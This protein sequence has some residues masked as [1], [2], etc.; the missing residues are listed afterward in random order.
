MLGSTTRGA[1][2]TA[3]AAVAVPVLHA[4]D[5]ITAVL[6]DPSPR[7][8]GSSAS[9]RWCIAAVSHWYDPDRIGYLTTTL[10]AVRCQAA[11]VG[12]AVVT[13][14]PARLALALMV[15]LAGDDVDVRAVPLEA[16]G[17]FLLG[18]PDRIAVVPWDGRHH[19]YRLTW[20][21]K[22]VFHDLVLECS[23]FDRGVTQ[24][25]YVE[26]DMRLDPGALDYWCAYRPLLEPHG[27]LPGFVRAEGRPTPSWMTDVVEPQV[28]EELPGVEVTVPPGAGAGGRA[29]VRCI[30]LTNPY[31]AMYVLDAPLAAWHFRRSLMRSYT[32]SRVPADLVVHWGTRERASM[33]P[34]L[35]EVP[36]GFPTRNVLPVVE[37]GGDARFPDA[38]VVEHLPANYFDDPA[39]E[40]GKLR[41]DDALVHARERVAVG[42]S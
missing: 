36:A 32:R 39:S 17:P 15:S 2:R 27:L 34:I 22:R 37:D 10:R 20:F 8:A 33:G 14:E 31:Q 19:P 29:T 24:L 3:E 42:A 23:A 26:D 7:P 13:N 40:F 11:R 16:A 1:L 18:G 9:D 35:D 30:N 4:V 5:A 6:D 12:C 28:V 38:C 25:L 41:R 21:H